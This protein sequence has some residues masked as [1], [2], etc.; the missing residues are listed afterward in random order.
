MPVYHQTVSARVATMYNVTVKALVGQSLAAL[1]MT[2]LALT[3]IAGSAQAGIGDPPVSV[4]LVRSGVAHRPLF[5]VS[6]AH[7]GARGA[8]VGDRGTV[9]LTGD[10]GKSWIAQEVDTDL[11]LLDV[12]LAGNRII[13]VGQMG[14]VM[15][16]DESGA[17]T[18]RRVGV[19]ERLLSIDA[20]ED[21]LAVA[22]G[23]F[24]EVWISTDGGASWAAPDVAFS[25]FVEEGYDPHLYAVEITAAGRIIVAGEFGLVVVSD[26]RGSSWR[27][28]RQGDE[29]IS[30]VHVRTDGNGYAVGQNGI[31][32]KTKDSGDHWERVDPGL[33]GNLLG[34]S[35]SPDGLVIVPGM[36]NML[37]S[38]DDGATFSA[39]PDSDVNSN[40]YQQAATGS[41]GVFVVGHT[42]RVLRLFLH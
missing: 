5:G 14:L 28:V 30:A 41:G 38:T 35:S 11:A 6:F 13:A 21:G 10:G 9:L 19:E 25:S 23:G 40:W 20:H 17:W 12:T 8:A 24:G 15:V 31:V 29:S 7:D 18:E 26:D 37:V 27:L 16:R 1:A 33:G 32:L 42:G 4:E 36:R 22:V 34:V 2:V 3:G 39:V